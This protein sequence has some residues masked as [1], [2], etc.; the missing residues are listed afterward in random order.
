MVDGQNSYV[1]NEYPFVRNNNKLVKVD[2]KRYDI[3][4]L[5]VNYCR[6]YAND[7]EYLLVMDFSEMD[8]SCLRII[9]FSTSVIVNI[10]RI[11]EIR[12]RAHCH[13]KE[14]MHPSQKC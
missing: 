5:N 3:S 14:P 12:A 4:K 2:I 8:E 10:A 13:R 9:L 11:D 1:L 6:I 7:K